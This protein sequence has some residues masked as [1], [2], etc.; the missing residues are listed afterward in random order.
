MRKWRESMN[1]MTQNVRAGLWICAFVCL[2]AQEARAA[3]PPRKSLDDLRDAHSAGL[4]Y[5]ALWPVDGFN[6]SWH[7]AQLAAG[8]R[9]MPS[10]RL[11]DPDY[12]QAKAP[13]T[14]DPA[15]LQAIA[16][17]NVPLIL[18]TN[19]IR[20]AIAKSPRNRSKEIATAATLGA[21]Y[22]VKTDAA[23]AA[24]ADQE[25]FC[26]CLAPAEMW[27]G[28]GAAWAKTPF[29]RKLR[30][31]IPSPPGL[32][33]IEN[34]EGCHYEQRVRY[35]LAAP[36]WDQPSPG[37]Q[38][39]E[40]IRRYSARMA[41]WLAAQPAGS[42]TPEALIAL[43][44]GGMQ[45]QYAAFYDGFAGDNRSN[46]LTAGYGGIVLTNLMTEYPW[47]GAYAAATLRYDAM[48]P[49]WYLNGPSLGD[50]TNCRGACVTNPVPA[51]E[52]A[53]ARNPRAWR[54]LSIQLTDG[55][56]L[57]GALAGTHQPISPA[58]W[59]GYC[60]WLLW[61]MQ[62]ADHRP[63]VLRHYESAATR[64]ETKLFFRDV[65]R[66]SG[67]ALEKA[68]AANE[69][70]SGRITQAGATALADVTIGDYVLAEASACDRIC[71]SAIL[72]DF[73]LNGTP[74]TTSINPPTDIQQ[75]GLKWP[76]YPLPGTPD[77]RG[78]LLP[79]DANDPPE[80][81]SYNIDKQ[82]YTGSVKVWACASKHSD[83]R[84]LVFAW[85]PCQLGKVTITVPGAGDVPIDLTGRSSAHTLLR[86]DG[87]NVVIEDVSPRM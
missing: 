67:A 54:E 13:Q 36:K 3:D 83:G 6:A 32:I 43:I 12:W 44:R 58:L 80:K 82:T 81:W 79:C 38:P 23:G 46:L 31:L 73:W 24:Y 40:T 8:H 51:W 15:A 22:A 57:A 19:N 56:A 66:L 9:V 61:S 39:V 77:N 35:L 20:D 18:R 5:V 86:R 85:T 16:A 71:E 64:P 30:T 75:A 11:P 37:L 28:E 72:R 25:P 65:S 14:L 7:A 50:F 68:T 70:A 78:R 45:T 48:S 26:D 34:N 4:P 60:E 41:D 27:R 74:M 21:V 33:L 2:L 76:A 63:C 55:A 10:I 29:Y 1:C 17:A 69:A 53:E 52:Q 59:Q 62:S 87:G 47:S 49:N 42:V 84:I